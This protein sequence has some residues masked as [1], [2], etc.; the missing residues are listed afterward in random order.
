[1]YNKINIFIY[2]IWVVSKQSQEIKS[3]N[4]LALALDFDIDL[5]YNNDKKNS[6]CD[7]DESFHL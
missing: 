7:S 2:Y 6:Y 5:H 3:N 4:K 1:M